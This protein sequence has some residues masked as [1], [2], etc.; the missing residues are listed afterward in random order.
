M[1]DE[2]SENSLHASGA[3]AKHEGERP[4]ERSGA[5]HDV[6]PGAGNDVEPGAEHE[7]EPGADLHPEN[8]NAVYSAPVY[9]EPPD[10]VW[11]RFRR[12]SHGKKRVVYALFLVAIVSTLVLM[13]RDS[14]VR[15]LSSFAQSYFNR[16]TKE[17]DDWAYSIGNYH[18]NERE[19]NARFPVLL[20]YTWG[21]RGASAVKNDAAAY[22]R[23]LRDQLET[24]LL[25]H[26]ALREG[27]LDSPEA[28]IVL[29]NGVRR[30][31][32]EYYLYTRI[33]NKNSDFRVN[34]DQSE[35][36]QHYA[37]NKEFYASRGLERRAALA[38]IE[39]TMLEFR[40]ERLRNRLFRLK[41][42]VI[43]ELRDSAGY[44]VRDPSKFR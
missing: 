11:E 40:R 14:D 5:E 9:L 6:E 32:A 28:R 7:G 10:T 13:T 43:D 22:R 25:V 8:P 44:R 33:R 12:W 24:D 35:I 41:M 30:L 4:R 15:S 19:L 36:E 29:E 37:K 18:I 2:K 1:K 31:I 16:F 27:A 39:K 26:A 23:Y 3:E 34:V 20:R 21:A 42:K 17:T 38:A